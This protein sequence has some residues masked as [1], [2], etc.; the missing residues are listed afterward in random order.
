MTTQLIPRLIGALNTK[1]G[2]LKAAGKNEEAAHAIS[3]VE[4]IEQNQDK[5]NTL[6]AS[7]AT[8]PAQTALLNSVTEEQLLVNLGKP[9]NANSGLGKIKTLMNI[10]LAMD[11]AMVANAK[12]TAFQAAQK[13]MAVK[14]AAANRRESVPDLNR[15]NTEDAFNEQARKLRE[16]MEKEQKALEE[17]HDVLREAFGNIMSAII[18]VEDEVEEEVKKNLFENNKWKAGAG[19]VPEALNKQPDFHEGM[20]QLTH[21]ISREAAAR[22]LTQ[23]AR[24]EQTKS[25]LQNS[26]AEMPNDKQ[27]SLQDRLNLEINLV[28]RIN[29]HLESL[30]VAPEGRRKMATDLANTMIDQGGGASGSLHDLADKKAKAKIAAIENKL[31]KQGMS[32]KNMPFG[33]LYGESRKEVL[34]EDQDMEKKQGLKK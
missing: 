30:G 6:I 27:L 15:E 33:Q 31:A 23:P 34:S 25:I 8:T 26:G 20:L 24:L 11:L 4:Y 12:S 14:I 18:E 7:S 21:N 3:M 9:L 28:K 10:T 22:A 32:L 16:Q 13:E 17:K 2:Q 19:G 5:I 1:I 29:D